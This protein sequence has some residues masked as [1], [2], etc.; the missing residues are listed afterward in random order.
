MTPP[1][2]HAAAVRAVRPGHDMCAAGCG[3][4]LDPAARVG[5]DG[6]RRAFDRH[7]GCEHTK[8]RTRHLRSVR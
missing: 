5:R 6:D 3:W 8:T 1:T 4:P 7:P 2:N